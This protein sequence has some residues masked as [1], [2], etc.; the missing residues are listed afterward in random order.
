MAKL[1]G[2]DVGGTFTDVVSV[3]DAGITT[4]KLATDPAHTADE[5][6]AGA[7]EI[8]SESA[9]F[10]NHASTR[11]LN[12]VITRQLPKIAFLTTFGHRDIL[13]A[14]R[15]WRPVA[16]QTNPHWRR[17]FGDTQLPLVPR[18]LRRGIL[19]RITAEG[20]RQSR[21]RPAAGR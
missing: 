5:V 15:T 20:R 11:G 9:L 10:F 18:Y 19:E 16:D 13:D 1:V 14:G 4:T 21:Y 8:E 3:D 6:L 2:V 17:R 12:A 7:C